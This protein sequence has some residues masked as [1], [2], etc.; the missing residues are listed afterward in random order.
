MGFESLF[1]LFFIYNDYKL[2]M[3]YII[4]KQYFLIEKKVQS[5]NN[6]DVYTRLNCNLYFS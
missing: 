4:Y 3:L 6:W 2:A 5:W 1:W